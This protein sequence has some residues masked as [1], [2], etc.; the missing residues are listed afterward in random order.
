[1]H[2]PGEDAG[3]SGAEHGGVST[4]PH[5]HA[6]S[7]FRAA[8]SER[9]ISIR[10]MNRPL[11][12]VTGLAIA[13]IIAA[14]LLIALRDH[15]PQGPSISVYVV[16]NQLV[17]MS[18]PVLVASI[19]LLSIG[20]AYLL[21]GAVHAH[22][23]L[24]VGG[25]GLFTWAMWHESLVPGDSGWAAVSWALL[26]GIWLVAG[27]AHLYDLRARRR[28]EEHRTH[29]TRLV[30]VTFGSIL[31]LVGGLYAVAWLSVRG[32]A[33]LLF[34]EIFTTQL[35]TVSVVL[36]PILLVAGVDFAD[37][38]ELT[39]DFVSRTVARARRNAGWL[40]GAAVALGAAATVAWQVWT[41]R[42]DL[43]DLGQ[44]VATAC[45]A[46]VLMALVMWA[47]RLR[48]SGRRF[49]EHVPYA[50]FAVLGVLSFTITYLYLYLPA[51]AA[52]GSRSTQDLS[53]LDARLS[54]Y[55][56]ETDPEFSVEHPQFWETKVASEQ[57]DGL[58]VVIVDGVNSGD[59][60]FL[61]VIT[62]P[63]SQYKDTTAAVTS[64]L[65]GLSS[66]KGPFSGQTAYLAGSSQAKG[67]EVFD[68]RTVV[69]DSGVRQLRGKLWTRMDDGRAWVLFG[70]T[71]D[72]FWAYNEVGF[73]AVAESWQ[74]KVRVEAPAATTKSDG[75]RDSDRALAVELGA[76]ALIALGLVVW[77]RR[78]QGPRSQ[79]KVATAALY[80][81]MVA[82]LLVAAVPG[83]LLRVATGSSHGLVGLHI[84]GIQL[85]AGAAVL[86]WMAV[87]L[88]RGRVGQS[89]RPLVA[90][91]TLLLGLQI[92]AWIYGLFTASAD[93]SGRFSIAEAVILVLALMW[94]IAFSGETITNGGNRWIPRHAR[95]SL[96][97]GY[98]MLVVA[99]ILYF[100][101]LRFPGGAQVEAQ[102]ESDTW[103]QSGMIELG[104]PLLLTLFIVK[105]S[106]LWRER[107]AAMATPDAEAAA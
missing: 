104:V 32:S 62:A 12:L 37:F 87:L 95:V 53:R 49:S 58:T 93:A 8:V 79:G 28:G 89:A 59:P 65:I 38:G 25:L 11:R 88:A 10:T 90:A 63:Q 40:L 103:V 4:E 51:S 91:G 100:S 9:L 70:F 22:W 41:F 39:S 101:S 84:E 23:A 7:S 45:V 46:L 44:E 21:T 68:V 82:V 85:F 76:V 15:G 2:S 73:D 34:T 14:A 74:P 83:P 54:P 106:R 6:H 69:R 19:V 96:Y 29:L 57:P 92:V 20:W 27:L 107:S 71:F 86:V 26:G 42:S 105:M 3:G 60:A 99:D 16:D 77:A 80:A 72:K 36:I 97:F 52:A 35:T 1:M 55:N 50:A 17:R 75:A 47:V 61:E 81:G 67:W 48:R 56:H 66:P 78:R 31:A 43:R 102:F 24:R 30:L 98:V 18:L 5:A 64:V 94:D 13:W 33:P